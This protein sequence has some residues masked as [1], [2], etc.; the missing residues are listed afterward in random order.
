MSHA[1]FVYCLNGLVIRPN[2]RLVRQEENW[3]EEFKYISLENLMFMSMLIH[4]KFVT[5][6][7]IK[8]STASAQANTYCEAKMKEALYKKNIC[9]K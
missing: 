4:I 8:F 6:V 1:H 7:S 5:F 3:S 2:L 9:Q